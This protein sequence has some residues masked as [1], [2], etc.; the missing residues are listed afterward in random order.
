M[1]YGQLYIHNSRLMLMHLNVTMGNLNMNQSMTALITRRMHF[2]TT[3][4]LSSLPETG[5]DVFVEN[6]IT[7]NIKAEI[8]IM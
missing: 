5:G 4:Q 3:L 8:T 6:I 1:E 7:T 2:T